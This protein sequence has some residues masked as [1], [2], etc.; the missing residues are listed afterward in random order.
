MYTNGVAPY[1]SFRVSLFHSILVST[2]VHVVS[3]VSSLV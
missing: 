3:H 2:S 1:T